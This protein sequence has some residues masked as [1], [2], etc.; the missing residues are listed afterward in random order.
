MT[1]AS[2]QTAVPATP[3]TGIDREAIC[4]ALR[5][6]P[7]DRVAYDQ[8]FEIGRF[9]FDQLVEADTIGGR[10]TYFFD[11]CGDCQRMFVFPS[12]NIVAVR[13]SDVPAGEDVPW[14]HLHFLHGDCWEARKDNWGRPRP[15]PPGP[16]SWEIS[17]VKPGYLPTGYVPTGSEGTVTICV[18]G[19][20]VLGIDLRAGTVFT[21][22]DG[23]EHEVVA[24]FVPVPEET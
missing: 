12:N 7:D 14:A 21:W 16:I 4:A 9:T 15:V 17:G 6:I 19:V 8:V 24:Q 20:G 23:E 1:H 3:P 5:A 18:D 13:T 11:R 2:E 22:P 10:R